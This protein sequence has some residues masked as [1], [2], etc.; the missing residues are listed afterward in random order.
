DALECGNDFPYQC[1]LGIARGNLN[2]DEM[3]RNPVCLDDSMSLNVVDGFL[4]V[5]GKITA[6]WFPGALVKI[7]ERVSLLIGASFALGLASR[8]EVGISGLDVLKVTDGN[9]RKGEVSLGR[10]LTS[11]ILCTTFTGRENRSELEPVRVR[12]EGP[13][14][15]RDSWFRTLIKLL[16][17]QSE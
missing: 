16:N 3:W 6:A 12:K 4:C 5:A 1:R 7:K 9:V 11:L 17:D 10:E 8:L 2:S 15:L 14:G 13:A